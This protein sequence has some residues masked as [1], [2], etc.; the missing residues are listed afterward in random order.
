MKD[1]RHS[2]DNEEKEVQIKYRER[3]KIPPGAWISVFF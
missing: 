3:K 1:K 2:Q